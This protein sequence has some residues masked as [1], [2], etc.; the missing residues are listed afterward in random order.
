MNLVRKTALTFLNK[1]AVS[2]LGFF[3]SVLLARFNTNLGFGYYQTSA[4]I[5]SVP[6]TFFGGYT[7]Y[8]AYAMARRDDEQA[9]VLQVGNLFVFTLCAGVALVAAA[10]RISGWVHLANTVWWALACMPFAI[11]FNHGTKLLQGQNEIG[12]LNAANLLQP[13][14]LVA[15]GITLLFGFR[16]LPPGQ[17]LH[18][19]YVAWTGSYALAAVFTMSS[20]W[21]LARVPRPWRIAYQ[22]DIWR[23][24][25]RYGSWLSVSNAVNIVNYRIDFWFVA[26]LWPRE[27]S[28]YA[29]AVTA[30]EVL[31]QVSGS[32]AVVVFKQMTSGS[33]TDAIRVTELSFRHTLISSV[34]AAIPMYVA[35][36]W[37]IHIA[38][39]SRYAGSVAPFL[40]LL[41]GLI[42]KSAGNVL[43]Q[44][45]TNQ[46]GSP[47]TSIWMNGLCAAVNAAVCVS[48]VP[49]F[50]LPGAALASTASYALSLAVYVAWFSRVNQVPPSGLCAIRRTDF[51][52]YVD[53]V[54]AAWNRSIGRAR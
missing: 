21:R 2:V 32:I 8:Y 29:I 13:A 38:Y 17:R 41:P 44:Y 10:L 26:A 1:L 3:N 35:F 33:R 9:E 11:L 25:W 51:V 27:A 42:L 49:H 15:V 19:T 45:A 36:P 40:I 16:H 14:V 43:I 4:S 12:R 39:G 20:A 23:E 46:L 7:G 22:A 53:A 47:Q 24:M 5:N 48:L 28:E 6:T 37:L 52:P 30:S 18:W 34:I 31:L 54:R 50:A